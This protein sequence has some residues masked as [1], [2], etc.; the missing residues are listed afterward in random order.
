MPVTVMRR[1]K[2]D[3]ERLSRKR[4]RRASAGKVRHISYGRDASVSCR[5]VCVEID[6][7][8]FEKFLGSRNS[9]IHPPTRGASK[10]FCC[11]F[12]LAPPSGRDPIEIR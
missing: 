12:E 5:C 4:F 1:I 8:D 3:R 11:F 6:F 2:D 10:R 7:G 9:P